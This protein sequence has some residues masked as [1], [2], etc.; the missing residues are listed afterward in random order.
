MRTEEEIENHIEELECF[1]EL[2]PQGALQLMQI[3]DIEEVI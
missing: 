2:E 1:F 3:E